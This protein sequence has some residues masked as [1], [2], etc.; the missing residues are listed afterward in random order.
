MSK[1]DSKREVSPEQRSDAHPER[2]PSNAETF[3]TG[4]IRID[5]ASS[6]AAG[7]PVYLDSDSRGE[8]TETVDRLVG[9]WIRAAQSEFLRRLR[10]WP[11]RVLVAEKL[12]GGDPQEP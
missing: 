11:G 4:G 7:M 5:I 2:G 1:R 10:A 9:N 12:G 8:S 6:I 3:G